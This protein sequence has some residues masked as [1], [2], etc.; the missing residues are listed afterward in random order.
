M[1]ME[2]ISKPLSAGSSAMVQQTCTISDAGIEPH[3]YTSKSEY[4]EMS[5]Y[6][7]RVTHVLRA[8]IIISTVHLCFYY[9]ILINWKQIADKSTGQFLKIKC[10]F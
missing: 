6:S 8:M 4:C 3:S 2:Y 9:K 5:P 10:F 1:M 7:L